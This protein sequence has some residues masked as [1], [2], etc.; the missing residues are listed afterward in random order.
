MTAAA[1]E[2]T[3]NSR[4]SCIG[5]AGYH[6]VAFWRKRAHPDFVTDRGPAQSELAPQLPDIEL[7]HSRS[8][9]TPSTCTTSRPSAGMETFGAVDS[10]R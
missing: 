1:G 4:Q 2:Q 7:I 5:Q 3:R 9:R 6:A 10:S 8:N